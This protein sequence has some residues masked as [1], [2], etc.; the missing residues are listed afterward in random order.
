MAVAIVSF[1]TREHLDACLA[2][3]GPE[4]PAQTIVVDNGSRDGS[5]ELVRSRYPW[6]ELEVAPAN[7][8]YGAAANRAIAHCSARYVFLLNSDTVLAPGTLAALTTYLDAHPRAAI[9]GPRLRN[10]DGSLQASCYPFLGTFQSFLEKTALGPVLARVPV[11]RDRYLLVHSAHARPRVVPWVLGAALAIRRSAFE[12]VGGFDESFLLYAEEVDLSY[13][14]MTAGW[15]VHFAPVTD[16]VHVGGVST[17]QYR[18]EMVARRTES[19]IHFYRRHYSPARRARLIAVIRAAMAARWLRDSLRLRIEG[20]G[21]RRAWL[22][23]NLTAWRRVLRGKPPEGLGAP[24]P[25]MGPA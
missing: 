23:E 20:D 22:A 2:T 4:A 1:N 9:V 14:L 7:R 11:L 12:A 8:G 25:G 5:I 18:G 16:V 13:R 3:V 15:E 21:A 17:R 24:P 19:A 10:P 6:V